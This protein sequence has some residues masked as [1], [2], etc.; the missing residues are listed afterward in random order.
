MVQWVQWP[1]CHQ[2]VVARSDRLKINDSGMTRHV[3]PASRPDVFIGWKRSYNMSLLPL[4]TGHGSVHLV[5]SPLWYV[6]VG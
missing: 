2:F 3:S 5:V 4:N 6:L 1:H